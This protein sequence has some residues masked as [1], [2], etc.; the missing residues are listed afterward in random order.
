MA[1][2]V[3]EY[4]TVASPRSKTEVAATC[5]IQRPSS[6]QREKEPR[7]AASERGREK[8]REKVEVSEAETEERKGRERK[9]GPL[10]RA[11]LGR[12]TCACGGK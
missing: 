11:C 6:R 12:V 10:R 2:P 8:E 3:K 1:W 4:H 7:S 5:P 9:H